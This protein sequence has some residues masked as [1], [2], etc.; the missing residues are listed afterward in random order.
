M[1]TIKNYL[2][3]MFANMPNTD[4]VKKAKQELLQMMEDKYSELLAE[5]KSENEAVGTVISEFGNLEDLSEDL[6][7]AEEFKQEQ[8]Y[9]ATNVRRPI[10]IE[11]AKSFISD[12]TKHGILVAIGVLL[13]ICCTIGPI[14][15]E[16]LALPDAIGVSFMMLFIATA[17]FLFVFSSIMNGKWNYIEEQPCSIDYNTANYLH[18][19]LARKNTKF[20]ITKTIG[21]VLCVICWVPTAV[22]ASIFEK[23]E[24]IPVFLFMTECIAPILLFIVVG[25][26]VALIVSTSYEQGSYKVLLKANDKNT[27]SGYYVPEQKEEYITPELTLIMSLFWPTIT[28]IYLIWSFLTFD[29]HISWTIWP[30]AAIIHAVIKNNL[31]KVD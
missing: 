9:S 29:W 11:E 23:Y 3:T 1:E 2:E 6:G 20:A 27:M 28:C 5:G 17:V 19:E 22:V 8:K 7:L 12:N 31:K 10:T 13:C 30:I 21:I 16:G 24:E 26:G 14:L 4:A 18:D 15:S 25:V